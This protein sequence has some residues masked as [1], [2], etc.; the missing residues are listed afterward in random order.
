MLISGRRL[1]DGSVKARI[2][3]FN[4][5]S[6]DTLVEVPLSIPDE[7]NQISVIGSF[8]ADPLLPLIGRGIFLAAFLRHNHEPSAHF[9]NELCAN[10]EQIEHWGQPVVLIVSSEDDA[11]AFSVMKSMPENVRISTNPGFPWLGEL[12]EEF[13]MNL[14]S[15]AL[16]V[17]LVADSF[18]RVMY[19]NK[20]YRPDVVDNLLEL[21]T[22]LLK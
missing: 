1:A 8:N 17:V 19:L 9:I 4:V 16:P 3:E 10:K 20:G 12:S 21:F 6:G 2:S 14:D 18:N 11:K 13:E 15:D 7:P 5:Y 22:K